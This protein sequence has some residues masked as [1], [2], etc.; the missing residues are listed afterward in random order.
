MNK[1]SKATRKSSKRNNSSSKNKNTLLNIF[2][3][4][5][6]FALLAIYNLYNSITEKIKPQAALLGLTYLIITYLWPIFMKHKTVLV[7]IFFI[8]LV[9][10][11][12]ISTANSL[13]INHDHNMHLLKRI[14]ELQDIN[15]RLYNNKPFSIIKGWKGLYCPNILDQNHKYKKI[16]VELGHFDN[17]AITSY[18][19]YGSAIDRKPLVFSCVGEVALTAIK[20]EIFVESICDSLKY[21]S[22]IKLKDICGIDNEKYYIQEANALVKT[23]DEKFA[24]I[25]LIPINDTE[26]CVRRT[27]HV[28]GV[29]KRDR[30]FVIIDLRNIEYH[31]DS[32]D[33]IFYTNHRPNNLCIWRL[34]KRTQNSIFNIVLLLLR[35]QTFFL[36][37]IE[38]LTT[39]GL[40]DSIRQSTEFI[41]DKCK[42]KVS[43][44]NT[45]SWRVPLE[46]ES[47]E[48]IFVLTYKVDEI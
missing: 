12:A 42:G 1:K 16:I 20:P 45:F 22:K 17:T 18:S 43:R 28:Q 26:F 38:G 31:P 25:S 3:I 32:C 48:N 30:E 35:Y 21:S 40:T 2:K 23:T 44:I 36:N 6:P 34:R 10:P 7:I 33:I 27:I 13:L 37:E 24:L 47:K 11:I 39:P 15:W 41:R 9:I 4:F 46:K 29:M 5:T 8:L 14:I 19:Y